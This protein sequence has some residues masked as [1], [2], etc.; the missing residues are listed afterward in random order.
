MV[1]PFSRRDLAA[2]SNLA[3]QPRTLS[4]IVD[5]P[6]SNLVRR[7]GSTETVLHS[8]LGGTDVEHQMGEYLAMSSII[9]GISSLQDHHHTP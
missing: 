7:L 8:I 9:L 4:Q 5:L 6:V 1:P 3:H 2:C